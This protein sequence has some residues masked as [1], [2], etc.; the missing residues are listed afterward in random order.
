MQ[1]EMNTLPH[2]KNWVLG[3]SLALV[4]LSCESGLMQSDNEL[5]IIREGRLYGFIDEDGDEP[6]PKQFAF[7]VNFSEGLAAVN[8]GGHASGWD[9]PEDGKWGFINRDGEFVINPIYNSP[10]NGGMPYEF[11]EM[12]KVLHQGYSFSEGLAAIYTGKE[13]EYINANQQVVIKGLNIQSARRFTEGLAA[14]MI[15]G[16][17]GYIDQRGII[18]I[19]PRY[20][21]PVDFHEG[22]VLLVDE[23]YQRVC[24][25]KKG[26]QRNSQYRFESG[27][28]NG[29]A[30]V[31][32]HFKG[33]EMTETESKK[34]G[35]I[36]TNR[37]VRFYPMFD[38]VRRF[39]DGLCPVLV[40]SKPGEWDRFSE[41]VT[42]M[43]YSGG[44]WGYVDGWGSFQ[45]NPVF[46]DAKGFVNGLAAVK[47]GGEWGL[48]NPS[49]AWVVRPDFR[50]VGYFHK[51]LTWAT[52]GSNYNN[53]YNKRAYVDRTG[54]VVWI[55]P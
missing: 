15:N 5:Y 25:D 30:V 22:Y 44:L 45:R 29:M 20:L 4:M 7:A 52:L 10:P 35:L 41:N 36:D 54:D 38:Q 39:G 8:V 18:V 17:W 48:I 12:G 1:K 2:T 40:G 16:K 13:W 43:E 24:L 49:G 37:L 11:S 55:E 14:V 53:Y 51:N 31:K 33:V 28:Y 46:H 23:N 9:M 27:F 3:I 34:F 26:K 50:R 6:F 19:E 21:F 42:P 32:P 47:S